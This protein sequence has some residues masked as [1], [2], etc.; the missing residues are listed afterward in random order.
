MKVTYQ[1]FG[2]ALLAFTILACNST[3][4][5]KTKDGLNYKVYSAGSGDKVALGNVVRYHMTNKLEDSLLGSTYGSP[6][7]WLSI[8]KTGEPGGL[9]FMFLQ[10]R[11]GDSILVIQPVD[12]VIAKSP[13]AAQDSFL[14]RNKGKNLKTYIKVVEVY[15]DEVAAQGMFEKENMENYFKDPAMAQQRTTDNAAI[16]NYLK[17][18][19]VSTTKSP[20]GTYVQVLNPGTGPKAKNGQYVSLRYR[21]KLLS[22]EEFDSNMKPGAPLLPLQIG[23]GQSIIGFEDGAKQLAKGGKANIYIPSVI[24]Y[25]AQGMPPKIAPNQNLVFEIEVVDITDAPAAPPTMPQ[26][27]STGK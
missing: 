27:D 11:K 5:K 3:D 17:A 13:Q 2:V 4:Y 1:I 15:R 20:W 8:P 22:G 19:N 16:E 10:A 25:G 23:A 14:M 26:A 18:N 6:A 24:G 12:S 7:R 21:G 9:G